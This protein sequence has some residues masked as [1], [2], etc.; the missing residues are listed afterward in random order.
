MIFDRIQTLLLCI[1]S[2]Q[3]PLFLPSVL[4]RR[5]D[6][7]TSSE[8]VHAPPRPLLLDHP[9]SGWAPLPGA[10]GA[11]AASHVPDA[12]LIPRICAFPQFARPSQR[13]WSPVLLPAPRVNF[14][15]MGRILTLALPEP[16]GILD[17]GRVQSRADTA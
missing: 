10:Q 14:P 8:A 13:L 5:D 12:V 4:A 15:S 3:G 1:F 7:R 2:H 16:L 9:T 17:T 11:S 6:P